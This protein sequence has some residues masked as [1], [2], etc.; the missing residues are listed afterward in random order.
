MGS[1]ICS[2][3]ALRPLKEAEHR[4]FDHSYPTLLPA[5]VGLWVPG[6]LS[7]SHKKAMP[8]QDEEELIRRIEQGNSGL[9]PVGFQM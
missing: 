8:C 6:C 2:T 7:R 4:K 1:C 5:G 9:L 3:K